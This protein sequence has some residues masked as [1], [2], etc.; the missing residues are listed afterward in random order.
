MQAVTVSDPVLLDWKL[1]L[2]IAKSNRH[3]HTYVDIVFL[4]L[5]SVYNGFTADLLKLLK[6]DVYFAVKTNNNNQVIDFMNYVKRGHFQV[7]FATSFGI[8][9][10]LLN[11]K[12]LIWEKIVVYAVFV[13]NF[14]GIEKNK[15]SKTSH[16]TWFPEN[17]YTSANW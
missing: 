1:C 7:Y 13:W 12:L 6:W 14:K 16:Y 9:M 5:V 11:V 8:L 15:I 17:S 10:D 4:T 3:V 2:R